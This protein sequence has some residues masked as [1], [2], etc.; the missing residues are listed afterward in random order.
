MDQN[1]SLFGLSID[2][3]SKSHFSETARWAKFLAIV[4]FVMCGLIVLMGVFFGSYMTLFMPASEYEAQPGLSALMST[5]MIIVCLVM[6]VLYFFPCL[7]LLRFS[8][9]MKSALIANDQEA[10]I[11]SVHNLKLVFR[12]VGI[13]TIIMLGIY[14]I[15][16]IISVLAA[17]MTSA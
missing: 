10:L 3:A 16:I 12:Y 1:T 2:P 4:G 9:H 14:G 5:T 6:A 11:N 15:S 7:F 17:A 8:N 13:L